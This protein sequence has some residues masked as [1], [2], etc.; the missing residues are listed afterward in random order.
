MTGLSILEISL[1]HTDLPKRAETM[2]S[3][4]KTAIVAGV[5]FITATVAGILSVLFVGPIPGAPDY[6]GR[7]SA[8]DLN[9]KIGALFESIMAFAGAGTAISMYPILRKHNVGAALAS[10]AFRIIEAVIWIVDVIGLLLLL[11]LSQEFLKAGSPSSSFFQT[12]GTLL[13]ALRYWADIFA[14]TAFILGALMYYSVFYR[15]RLIPRWL[16]GWGLVGVPLWLSGTLLTMFSFIS[17]YS[18]IQVV[19]FLPIAVQE[20][21][22]ATWLIVKGY[23]TSIT[24]SVPGQ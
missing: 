12:C 4:R 10:V 9:V 11:T 6:M 21:V 5:L 22:M 8:N 7:I 19:L 23:S 1:E 3:E 20:M 15:S 24:P 2:T 18:T 13:L 16:S 17:L 14:Y